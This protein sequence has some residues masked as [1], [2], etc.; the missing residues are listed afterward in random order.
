VAPSG[1]AIL[2]VP[3]P[4]HSRTTP[5]VISNSRGWSFTTRYSS[6]VFK[7]VKPWTDPA[8][9]PVDA[10]PAVL[11]MDAEALGDRLLEHGADIGAFALAPLRISP[12]A[13]PGKAVKRSGARTLRIS[14][15]VI[16]H[17]GRR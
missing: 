14:V 1:E 9:R 10:E 6:S 7:F 15:K 5:S 17:S 13:E 16:G 11:K 4:P 3:V 2:A 12:P 8:S